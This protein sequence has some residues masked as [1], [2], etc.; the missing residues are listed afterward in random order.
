VQFLAEAVLLSCFG[1]AAGI[2]LGAASTAVYALSQSWLIVIPPAA[3]VLGLAGAIFIGAVS[4][5]YPALRAARLAPTEALR[6]T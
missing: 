5:V 1:G 4:G 3:V 2:G 6:S